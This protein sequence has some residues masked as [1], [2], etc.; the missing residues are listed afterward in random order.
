MPED[1]IPNVVKD[2]RLSFGLTQEQFAA[3]VG[4]TFSTVNRWE[5]GRGRPSPLAMRQI[6]ALLEEVAGKTHGSRR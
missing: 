2:L 4:V 1:R 3:K 5:N 6:D